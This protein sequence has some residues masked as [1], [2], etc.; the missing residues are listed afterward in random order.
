M[1]MI[2]IGVIGRIT[3]V[4]TRRDIKDAMPEFYERWFHKRFMPEI[5]MGI[6]WL[7]LLMD[8]SKSVTMQE[9]D[10]LRSVYRTYRGWQSLLNVILFV[11]FVVVLFRF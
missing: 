9:L 5:G 8:D 1:I 3:L 2:V 4:A 11:S 10:M 7:L 6:N